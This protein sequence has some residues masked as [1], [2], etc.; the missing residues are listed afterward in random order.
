MKMKKISFEINS[1]EEIWNLIDKNIDY[2]FIHKFIP[3]N[4]SSW[5]KTNLKLPNNFLL[6]NLE[7][8][9]LEFDIQTN[10]DGL[11]QIIEMNTNQLRIYQFEKP[12]SDNLIL[13]SLPE[14]SRENI[15]LQNGLKHYY[16]CNF[17]FI[18]IES[19]DSEFLNQIKISQ[20]LIDKT[21]KEND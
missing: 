16:F 9:N 13:E 19:N 6:D 11:R 1:N 2:I 4:N 14:N 10:L 5:W 17:E 20:T 15:L 21:S 18:T 12:V 7:V 8:R 3:N